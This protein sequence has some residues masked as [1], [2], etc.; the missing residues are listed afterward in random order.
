MRA[1]HASFTLN[2]ISLLLK[3]VSMLNAASTAVNAEFLH[4]LGDTIGS[5]LLVLGLLMSRRRPSTRYPFGLGRA[6]Y[7]FGLIV[8]ALIGG[9]LFAVTSFS[10]VQQLVTGGEVISTTTSI[11]SLA[12]ALTLDLAIL[13]WSLIELRRNPADPSA[14]GTLVE[15]LADS[16]GGSA[17]LTSLLLGSPFVDGL[18]TLV[19]SV[20]LLSSSALLSYRY[21]EV[22][23]GRAAPK[24]IVGRV[25]K[26][27]LS[28][29]RIVDVNDVKSLVVGPGEFL[30]ML[31]VEV[32]EGTSVDEIENVRN[33]LSKRMQES[34][35]GVKYVVIEFQKP[36]SPP[37]SFKRVL[38]EILTLGE[39]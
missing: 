31:Q 4:A 26:I 12:T 21:F 8:S 17:A 10:G 39:V 23:V 16:V 38:K 9:F 20:I 5:G 30:V 36:S 3:T 32:P 24:N 29:P 18:G 28:D 33:E 22:L 27:A 1:A 13:L 25:V 37:M 35:N 7:V 6:V 34:V 19:V 14:K 2:L 11:A 15:N